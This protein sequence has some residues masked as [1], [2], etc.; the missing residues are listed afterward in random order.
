MKKSRLCTAIIV[1]ALGAFG[2]D[3]KPAEKG[4]TE[5][6]TATTA[7]EADQPAVQPAA[8]P[9]ACAAY[10]DAVQQTC[11]AYF[12]TGIKIPCH[13]I[14]TRANVAIATDNVELC[15]QNH[16]DLKAERAKKAHEAKPRELG[17]ACRVFLDGLTNKCLS[18]LGAD[19]PAQC[20]GAMVAVG[21]L[22]PDAEERCRGMAAML[23]RL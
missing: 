23:S 16:T 22:G 2:C 15:K 18:R 5:A 10:A 19:Y 12:E 4:A 11:M 8:Q 7:I 3:D 17:E 1:V 20:G 13:R 9:G 6:K 14:V 21:E